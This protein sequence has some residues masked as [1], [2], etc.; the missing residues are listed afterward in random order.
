MNEKVGGST[1]LGGGLL[2]QEEK[3]RILLFSFCR[4]GNLEM[5]TWRAT[6]REHAVVIESYNLGRSYIHSL[7][8]VP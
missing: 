4:N 5:G 8:F 6:I 1:N 2:L 7:Q 3:E